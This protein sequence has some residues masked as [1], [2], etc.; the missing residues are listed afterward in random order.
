MVRINEAI[1]EAV[2]ESVAFFGRKLTEER[3]LF[4]GMLGHDM[5]D[6]LEAIRLSA[7]YLAR[8]NAGDP[9]L[10]VAARISR[11]SAQLQALLNDLDFNRST[12]GLGLHVAPVDVSL[13]EL[14]ADTLEQLRGSHRRRGSVEATRLSF[15]HKLLPY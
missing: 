10:A 6:P 3:N 15:R 1:D 14:F 9:V 4:L 7:E 5:R 13:A 12:L 2:A 11:S 8:L